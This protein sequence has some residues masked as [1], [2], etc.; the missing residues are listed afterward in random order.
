M[1]F[2]NKIYNSE[3]FVV[4][5]FILIGILLA[6][7]IILIFSGRKKKSPVEREEKNITS[8]NDLTK[9][10]ETINNVANSETNVDA[11]SNTDNNA[12]VMQDNLQ[13]NMVN[14]FNA[15]NMNSTNDIRQTIN[16]EPIENVNNFDKMSF[17][18]EEIQGNIE[19]ETIEVS[20]INP[21]PVSSTIPLNDNSTVDNDNLFNTSIFHGMPAE[22]NNITESPV[23]EQPEEKNE[24][25]ND[26]TA[27]LFQPVPDLDTVP[28]EIPIENK[29]NSNNSDLN[30]M[31]NFDLPSISNI[32]PGMESNNQTIDISTVS[33]SENVQMPTM[34]EQPTNNETQRFTM[35]TQF[36]SVYVNKEEQK[37][38]PV[39]Q[40]TN[41][42]NKVPPY[43]PTLFT[44]ILNTNNNSSVSTPV[45]ENITE[46]TSSSFDLPIINNQDMPQM[47][48]IVPEVPALEP[49]PEMGNA[50]LNNEMPNIN[51]NNTFDFSMPSLATNENSETSEVADADNNNG[52]NNSGFPNF[53]S[54]TYDIK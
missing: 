24:Q 45:S 18:Q 14:N 23:I 7:F 20:P 15:S 11:L 40:T 48:T 26:L 42:Q 50:S 54:E 29:E 44:S 33:T 36:S 10:L 34:N 17:G 27:N 5:L 41:N 38:E 13:P 49:L 53:S 30:N 19:P 25:S 16:S 43:D 28:V 52:N 8:T 32:E 51:P 39:T 9:N 3:Y 47:D 12:S 46:K 37:V 21:E 2:I 22:L 6:I 31:L 4:G 35:P 1:D